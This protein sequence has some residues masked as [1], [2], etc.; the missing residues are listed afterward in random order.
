MEAS[1]SPIGL[2]VAVNVI[3]W[4]GFLTLL[5]IIKGFIVTALVQIFTNAVENSSFKTQQTL[6][7]FIVTKPTLQQ[8]ILDKLEIPESDQ[9]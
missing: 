3:F 4:V 2:E 1:I 7:K 5:Y 9:E 8:A 6:V